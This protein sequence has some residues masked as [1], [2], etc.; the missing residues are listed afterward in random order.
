MPQMSHV[1]VL[2]ASINLLRNVADQLSL[3]VH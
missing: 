1:R 3:Q 2:V